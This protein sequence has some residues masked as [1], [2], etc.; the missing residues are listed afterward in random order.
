MDE[1]ESH[2]CIR[3]EPKRRQPCFLTITKDNGCW[4]EGFGDCRPRISFGMGCEKYG[5]ILHELLHAIGFEH[6]HNRPDRSDY[7]IINWRNIEG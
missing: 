6:E 7:I 3:F 4:F 5:T 1:I 2:S